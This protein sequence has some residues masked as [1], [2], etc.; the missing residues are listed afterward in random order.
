MNKFLI[1]NYRDKLLGFILNDGKVTKINSYDSESQIGNVYV[2]QVT[3]VLANINAAFI[4]IAP[5]ESCYFSLEDYKGQKKLSTGDNIVV[6]VCRDKIKSKKPAVTSNISL[7]DELVLVHTDSEIGVS[8]KIKDNAR[9]KQLKELFKNCLIEFEKDKKCTGIQYGCIMRTACENMKDEEVKEHIFTMLTKLDSIMHYSQYRKLYSVVYRGRTPYIDDYEKYCINGGYEFV[10][11]VE[12][13]CGD[14][15]QEYGCELEC[16]SDENISITSLYNLNSVV[17]KAL[18]KRVYLKSGG[19]LVIEPTEAMTVIDVNTGKSVKGKDMSEHVLK[20]NK[21]AACEIAKQ[22]MLRNI[23]GIIMVDFISMKSEAQNKE[24]LETF[25]EFV[26]NDSVPTQIVDMTSLGLVEVT[27][28]KI[29]KS[30]N[31]IFS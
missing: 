2:G 31:E 20:T 12:Q 6:Q 27:R 14:I 16:Y 30:L 29:Q 15:S 3:N 1:T 17:D 4:D 22:L 21:E 23:S 24:L 7:T 8:A 10:S 9:K 19:Y 26:K 25:R 13:V 28:K 11:D 5:G 18:S